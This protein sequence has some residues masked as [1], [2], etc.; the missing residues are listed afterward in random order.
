VSGMRAASTAGLILCL[1]LAA[2]QAAAEKVGVA[3]AVNPDAYS[4]MSGAPEKQLS[5]GKSIFYNER[6]S[7]DA[8]GVVQVL[9]VDGS[10]FTVGA[11]SDLVIDRFVYDPRTKSG[12]VVATFSKGAMRFIGGKISKNEKGVTVNTPSGSLAIRGGMFQGSLAGRNSIFSFLYGEELT[13]TGNSGQTHTVYQPGYTLDFN[14]GLPTVRPTTPADTQLLMA[15]L[16]NSNTNTSGVQVPE[17]PR[18]TTELAQTQSLQQLIADATAT[19]IDGEL[20][21]QEAN[22]PVPNTASHSTPTETNNVYQGYAAGIVTSDQ[23]STGFVNTVFGT[24]QN[25]FTVDF[26]NDKVAMVLRDVEGTDPLVSRYDLGFQG[27]QQNTPG[28]LPGLATSMTAAVFD[29]D[30]LPYAYNNAAGYFISGDPY[31]ADALC[32][33]CGFMK[34]GAFGTALN[35]GNTTPND[36]EDTINPGWWIAAKLPTFS[37]LPQTGSATYEGTAL[38][39]VAIGP[40]PAYVARGDLDMTWNFASRTGNLS[41]TDFDAQGPR[42]PLNV[43]GTMTSPG[44]VNRFQGNLNG[45]LGGGGELSSAAGGAIGSFAKYKGDPAAGIIGNW[46]ANSGDYRATGIFGGRR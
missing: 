2:G 10:T 11:N 29:G 30:G 45:T 33:D 35:F 22:L 44:Q 15:Q 46:H 1:A 13:F 16:T 8:S 6:I 36:I 40:G 20:A 24:S 17:G 4:S 31:N 37:D 12:E 38:G 32:T 25:D 41:I 27:F 39:S 28:Q 5:I 42:G 7:T 23:P 18:Q 9:L 19:Q 26:D 21:R 43:S 14:G 34:W 3:A